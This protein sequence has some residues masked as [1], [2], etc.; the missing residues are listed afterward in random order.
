MAIPLIHLR[1]GEASQEKRAAKRGILRSS[2]MRLVIGIREMRSKCAS[3]GV[4]SKNERAHISVSFSTIMAARGNTIP[5]NIQNVSITTFCRVTRGRFGNS[6]ASSCKSCPP[7]AGVRATAQ[8]TSIVILSTSK[9]VAVNLSATLLFL[10]L[11]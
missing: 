5:H 1:S 2:P 11:P 7:V 6:L 4:G 3:V 10:R 8:A 9:Q